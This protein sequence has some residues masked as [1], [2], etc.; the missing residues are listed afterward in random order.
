MQVNYV[1]ESFRGASYTNPDYP[2]LTVLSEIMSH[3]FLHKEIREKGGAYGSGVQN[4]PH[5]GTISLYSYRDP[6][7]LKTYQAFEKSIQNCLKG[8]FDQRLIDEAK[9]GAFQRI[10]KPVAAFDKG[11]AYFMYSNI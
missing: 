8:E 10:D 5:R 2:V 3:N 7:N 1:I 9:L 4:D 6:N 11:L